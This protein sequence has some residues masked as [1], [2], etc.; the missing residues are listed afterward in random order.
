MAAKVFIDGEAGTTGLQIR[1]KLADRRDIELVSL[2][3]ALRKDVGAKRELLAD[4]DLTILCLPDEAAKEAAHLIDEMGA[5]GPRVIDASSAHRVAP[6]WVYGFPELTAG[7][8][9]KIRAAKLVSNPGC[10]AT[11][12]IALLRPLTEA[13][14][15][16]KDGFVS[17]G[18]VSGY[19]GGGKAMIEA[20]ESGRAPAFE[21]Y[22]LGLEHKHLPEISEYSGLSRRPAFLPSVASFRQG[23]LVSVAL[24]LE[25]LPAR[26]TG[27]DL[28][29]VY[30]RHYARAEFIHVQ[31]DAQTRIEPESLNG[32]NQLEIHVFA[33][34]KRRQALLMAKFDNLGKGASGA[35]VQNLDLMLGG[36]GTRFAK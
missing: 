24:D 8:A 15:L 36:G 28:Q 23:M 6:G 1:E 31:A 27:A 7:Q 10:H 12:A 19:S 22:G 30:S 5:K 35:A 13:G 4:V 14:L 26:P 29:A 21:H 20:Y 16:P 2:P 17:I 34:E 9:D 32:T 3:A 33:N 11:G 25:T 18:S